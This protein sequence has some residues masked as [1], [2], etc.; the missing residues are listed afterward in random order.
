MSL[1]ALATSLALLIVP[2][3]AIAH[4]CDRTGYDKA[5]SVV[6]TYFRDDTI[7]LF[8]MQLQVNAITGRE[9]L[10][11]DGLWGPSSARVVCEQLETYEAINGMPPDGLIATRD[12]AL[13]FARWMGAMS[14]VSLNPGKFEAPD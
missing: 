14:R 6:E 12:D 2:A 13:Q 11:P 4:G 3:T 5:M 9:V 8:N 1:R 10:E 7:A